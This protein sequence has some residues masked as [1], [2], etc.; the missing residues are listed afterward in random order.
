[1]IGIGLVALALVLGR[2]IAEDE[3]PLRLSAL[4]DSARARA[5]GTDDQ[6]C[7]TR[8]TSGLPARCTS[9][10]GRVSSRPTEAQIALEDALVDDSGFVP[11]PIALETFLSRYSALMLEPSMPQAP[12]PVAPPSIAIVAPIVSGAAIA[13]AEPV[14]RRAGCHGRAG[15]AVTATPA[16][17]APVRLRRCTAAAEAPRG[18]G[19]KPAPVAHVDVGCGRAGCTDAGRP[20]GEPVAK[21][22]A[23]RTG[24]RASCRQ[25][26]PPAP[27]SPSCCATSNRL[28][29]LRLP[30]P[31]RRRPRAWAWLGG[32]ATAGGASPS[33]RSPSWRSAKAPII[34]AR[35]LRK[36]PPPKPGTLSVQTNPP[37][38][39]VFVDGVA[40]GNTPARLTLDAG[41]HLVE[42]RGR[43]VPRVVP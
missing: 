16:P 34:A 22:G 29:R 25:T 24:C 21:A 7:P 36:P 28:S 17:V 8:C 43:G 37:G 6:P 20:G 15:R 35:V 11:A 2:P 40:Y 14:R 3:Y 23:A 4:L 27:T 9:R 38:V 10:S 13:A 31:R 32:G 19:W 12:E 33:S 39:D 41:S 5:A 30:R 1:M 18:D 26:S 42:L